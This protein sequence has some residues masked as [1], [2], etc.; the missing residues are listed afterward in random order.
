MRRTPRLSP[1][2][3]HDRQLS[4]MA[5]GTLAGRT[6]SAAPTPAAATSPTVAAP[7]FGLTWHHTGPLADIAELVS[8]E[9]PCPLAGQ[10][11]A[12]VGVLTIVDSA[13][14][15]ELDIFQNGVFVATLTILQGDK[16]AIVEFDAI[17]FDGIND[18]ANIELTNIGTDAEGIAVSMLVA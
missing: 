11:N 14:D 4:R 10:T 12:A 3:R 16:V 7:S 18:V 9:H 5:P 13:S 17:T 8:D 6:E 1:I 15:V 2:E